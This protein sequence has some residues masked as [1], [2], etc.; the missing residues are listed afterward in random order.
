M[1]KISFLTRLLIFIA[2]FGILTGSLLL[3]FNYLNNV[4]AQQFSGHVAWALPGIGSSTYGQTLFDFAIIPN[5]V[6]GRVEIWDYNRD[7]Q[8]DCDLQLNDGRWRGRCDTIPIDNGTIEFEVLGFNR[9]TQVTL[10]DNTVSAV[11]AN[12]FSVFAEIPNDGTGHGNIG[13]HGEISGNVNRSIFSI[14]NSDPEI[15]LQENREDC[16]LGQCPHQLTYWGAYFNTMLVPNGEYSVD[17][18]IETLAGEFI[19]Q[20][21]YSN[22]FTICNPDWFCEL[23]S[24]CDSSGTRTRTC[25]DQNQCLDSYTEQET[26]TI[27]DCIPEWH[28]DG[29]EPDPCP[30]SGIQTRACTDWNECGD[31]V[32][33]PEQDQTCEYQDPDDP[34]V[35]DPINTNTN[36]QPPINTNTNT[37]PPIN[38]NTN[39]QPPINTNTNTQPPINTNTNSIIVPPNI[40]KLIAPSIIYP[41]NGMSNYDSQPTVRGGSE[42]GTKVKIYFNNESMGVTTANAEGSYSFMIPEPI[43][44]QQYEIFVVAEDEQNNRISDE[45]ELVLFTVKAPTVTLI[46]PQNNQCFI[47][48]VVLASS[49]EGEIAN[50]SY[51]YDKEEG[52]KTTDSHLFIGEG[53]R[54]SG[55]DQGYEFTWNTSTAQPGNYYIYVEIENRAGDIYYSNQVKIIIDP[56]NECPEGAGGVIPG[57]QDEN[58][59]PIPR[60]AQDVSIVSEEPTRMGIESPKKLRVDKVDNVVPV[61]GQ[62]DLV[63]SGIGPPNSFLTLFIYS[64]PI[65]VTTKTDASGNF[66]YTLDKNLLDGKH[67]VYVTITDETGKILEKSSPFSFFVRRAQAISEEEY[68]RGDVNVDTS[69]TVLINNYLLIAI[70]IVVAVVVILLLA[71]YLS[72]KSKVTS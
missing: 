63:F 21:A 3:S 29:W 25:T 52:S 34:G 5:N 66:T 16:S 33:W 26:C 54:I 24:E 19:E 53:N 72:K 56:D 9:N 61:I 40:D 57:G 69:S 67:E 17:M 65:V 38:T 8:I 51:F 49:V 62:N 1:K 15:I 22:M 35:P 41:E 59:E 27:G 2:V 14:P 32:N 39:T 42:P 70:I 10:N 12:E 45:S 11:I 44:A 46:A 36:T 37:Q 50:L 13:I 64:D 60:V 28:C 43:S 20:V 71:V 30:E 55:N 6:V 68:L 58:K 23:W 18:S 7:I 31:T 4:R 47:Q 48:S